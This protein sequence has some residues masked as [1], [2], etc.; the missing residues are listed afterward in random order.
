MIFVVG[1][2]ILSLGLLVFPSWTGTGFWTLAAVGL[3]I[4]VGAVLGKIR[5]AAFQ[6]SAA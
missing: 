1:V 2:L 4:A 6:R 5:H 3:L